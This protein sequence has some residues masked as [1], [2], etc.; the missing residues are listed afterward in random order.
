MIARKIDINSSPSPV[1]RLAMPGA[2]FVASL[3]LVV[4]QKTTLHTEYFA[5]LSRDTYAQLCRSLKGQEQTCVQSV[6]QEL[7]Q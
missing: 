3:L 5:D 7:L 6:F 2:P 1:G 4:I